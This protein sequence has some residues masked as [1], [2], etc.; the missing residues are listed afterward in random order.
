VQFHR[1]S[2]REARIA[3]L[4]AEIENLKRLPVEPQVGFVYRIGGEDYVVATVKKDTFCLLHTTAWNRFTD[5]GD[6]RGIFGG[7]DDLFSFVGKWSDY[8][9]SK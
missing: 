8:V 5:V 9:K 3:Q 2:K 1:I 6:P 4:E 7:D